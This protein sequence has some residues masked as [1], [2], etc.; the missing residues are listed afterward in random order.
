MANE[1]S[2]YRLTQAGQRQFN[3]EIM[4]LP[5][6]TAAHA[7]RS[8][9]VLIRRPIASS[10]CKPNL[11]RFTV[12][13]A[14]FFTGCSLLSGGPKIMFT[15]PIKQAD[16]RKLKPRQRENGY[17]VRPLFPFQIVHEGIGKWNVKN[18]G[19]REFSPGVC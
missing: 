6:A 10:S 17:T 13:L 1:T 14:F 9:R 11:P 15:F 8:V 3:N 19:R 18:S 4:I 2:P 12:S 16:N 5:P 7:L